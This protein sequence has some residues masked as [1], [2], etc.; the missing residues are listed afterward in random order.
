MGQRCCHLPHGGE[1]VLLRQLLM[2]VAQCPH[3]M[4][5]EDRRP[6][7]QWAG[8]QGQVACPAAMRVGKVDYAVCIH[9][10]Q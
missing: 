7:V 1:L 9:L 5:E 2:Q 8:L 10:S 4:Q 3:V 6:V